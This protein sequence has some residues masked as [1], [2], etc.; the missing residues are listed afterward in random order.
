MTYYHYEFTAFTE[1]D[2]LQGGDTNLGSGDSFVMSGGPSVCI[3]TWDD[4][5]KL[6]GDY[7]DNATD[8]TG[9]YASVDGARVG[10]QMYAESYLTLR[11]SDGN[12]Y[13]LI[14]IEVEG[15][16]APGTGDDF[17]TF[18][19]AVP[20]A[21]VELTVTA[22]NDV[23]GH[24]VDY[25]CLSAGDKAPANTPPT[26]T[27]LPSDG[28]ITVDEN[29]TFVI[30]ANATDADGDTL[31]Y[32]IVGGRD[33][34]FFDIDAATGE[35]TFKSGPD[36]ENPQSGGNNNTYDVTIKVSDGNGGE[37]TKALWVKVNDVD[38]SDP[39]NCIEVLGQNLIVN[40]DFEDNALNN[41]GYG[42]FDSLPG[43]VAVQDRIE[44]QESDYQTGNTEGNAVAELDG[45]LNAIIR[46]EV[47]ITDAGTY[48][49][50][51]DYAARGTDWSTNGFEIYIDGV[52][53]E[54]VRPT[55]SG[56]QTLTF[57][58]ELD[59]GSTRIDL[60]GIGDSD[61]RGTVVDNVMLQHVTE[62]SCECIIIEAENMDLSGFRA[63]T[64]S[65]ASG[66][67]LVSM[68]HLGGTGDLSTTFTGASGSYELKLYA[69]DENDG[70]STLMVKVNGHVVKTIVLNQDGDGS[71]SDD[72]G[73]TAFTVDG[74][75][76]KSGDVV[77]IWAD[78]D[79]GEW[80][81]IDKIE[82]CK[83]GQ[84]CPEGY[85]KLDFEGLA[86]GTVV[87]DQFE[88]VTITAQRERNNT[89][90]NDAMIFDSNNWS[91]DDS[92]LSYDN[93]GNILIVSTDNN[94]SNP[95][96]AIGSSIVFDF[97]S[98]SDLH[99][100]VL[101]DIEEEGGTI[102]LTFEDGSTRV[103]DIPG[104][105]DNSIQTIDLNAA[106]VT[107][108]TIHLT[109]SGAVDDLCW[110][111]GEAVGS[112][113]GT[114][115]C[116]VECDGI[117]G[118]AGE[119]VEGCDYTIEA[120]DMN[121]YKFHTVEAADASGGEIVKLVDY[122]GTGDLRTD[123]AGKDGVY[124]VTIFA[125]DENDGQSTIMFKVNDELV[126]AVR[127]D[128]D[129]DGAGDD[130]GY[131]SQ[132]LI[133]G[134]ELSAGDEILMWVDGDDGEWVRI[135]KIE[136][137]GRDQ[138]TEGTSEPVK[139]GVTIKLIDVATDTVIATTTTDVDG[140]YEFTNVPVG[141]YKVMGVA[142]DGTEFTIQDAGT[143]DTIDSDVNDEGMSDVFTVTANSNS[144]IDLGVCD[145]PEL[146]SLS[147]RYFCDDNRDGL[148][149]DANNAVAGVVVT[150]LD[151]SG[152]PVLDGG[153]PVTTMTDADGN[154]S[155]AD[156]LPGDY[157]VRFE[158]T[159]DGKE[160]TAQDVGTD[161][162]IDSDAA[163]SGNGTSTIQGI[164]VTAGQDTPNNDVGV[165][166]Q[167]GSLSGT[168]FCDEDRD[169]VD[170]GAA[171]GD[172]DIAGK[173][174]TLYEADG[175]T[176]ATDIDGNP[177]APVQTDA[178]GDYRFDNLAAGNYVVV[179][180]GSD[181][182]AFV[183]QDT[184]SDDTIDSDVDATG[185][186]APVGVVAG[187]ETTDVDAGVAYI[188]GSLS[189]TYFCDDNR[190]G[191]DDGAANG[192]ADIAGKLVTLLNADG[193]PATDIDGNPV[194]AVLT[195]ANGDYSFDN[196]AAGDYKVMFEATDGK[197]FIAQ[198]A[199]ND[200]TD[201]SDV[202]PATGMTA[203]VTVVAGQNTPD[204][205]AG[206]QY[207]LGSLSGRY[208]CDDNRD[209]LDNDANNAVAGVV[210]T[211]LDAA[212]NPVLDGG[213]PV[214]TMTDADGN[215]SFGDLLPG[216]YG[217]R[218]ES[219]PD[220]KELTAQD[221]GTDDAID[222][223]A[224][225][226]GNG[227]STIQGI[228]VTAGQD[229]PNND[230]GVIYQPGSL[231]GTYFCDEDR[232]GVDDGAANGDLDI[233]GKTV[234][235]YEA[236]GVTPATDIDG[237][238]VAPVQT[239]ANGDYRFD[240][241]AAGNYVV[242]FEGSDDKAFVGQ[243]TGSDDTIDSDVDA[244]GTTA[245]VGV[246]AGEE[247]TDVD[248]GVAYLPGSLSGTYFC[249]DNRDGDDDGAA[250]GDADI[251]GK[252]VTL[253]NADGTPATD[254]D[255]NPVAPVLTDANGDY[256][257]D[258]LAAGDYKVMFEATDGKEFI[259]QDAG[260]DDTDDSDVDPA[261]GMTAPVTV[262]A[263]Q[264][265]PDV[266]A[267]VQDLLGSVSGTYFCDEN[268]NGAFDNE[269]G[270]G[271][272]SVT[273]EGA[274]DDGLFGTTD[275]ILLTT[276]TADDGTFA[277]ENLN[278]GDYKVS[279][280]GAGFV[281][282]LDVDENGMSPIIDLSAG[283]N[284]ELLAAS[285]C[286]EV[287]ST[288]LLGIAEIL[289]NAENIAGFG[290]PNDAGRGELF[291]DATD[292]SITGDI[293]ITSLQLDGGTVVEYTDAEGPLLRFD[294]AIDSNGD[295]IPSGESDDLLAYEDV[296]GNRLF[297]EGDVVLLEATALASGFVESG[298]MDF[299]FEVNGGTMADNFD[300]LIGMSV[301]NNPLFVDGERVT[302]VSLDEDF[303]GRPKGFV[304]D[305]DYDCFC[306][307]DDSVM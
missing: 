205:D 187:E 291:Y 114:V 32:E 292:G 271:N 89:A 183:D 112:V 300:P 28:I 59:A 94:S 293:K 301:G 214:T 229:T 160:L 15:Y 235:L 211:L 36:Y 13:Y 125:Q 126:E 186:T 85:A 27:N 70:Q 198:D 88:G 8:S 145:K 264:N 185:T 58:V 296:N 283:E 86:R 120:E 63:V 143:D 151:A 49:F 20:P 21:G 142:P 177:V 57:D 146:G 68:S 81:R 76:L 304:G 95:N 122:R 16:S 73:F 282:G 277:F 23:S 266:D 5:A 7:R 71:G 179:F 48:R 176:P 228:T 140:N 74:L 12:T 238:P 129:S 80:V 111:P 69:Q 258:N 108:M 212:G 115:F 274:G 265:T 234:T 1:A 252:L 66:G 306:F 202:D 181:D 270:I 225:D 41:T 178:N 92:D 159:P 284:L 25:R 24:W 30:D 123:F 209:G 241:L 303:I 242:V 255:G 155:F 47:Q 55:Q 2:L 104:V 247:T 107:K 45:D 197:E 200:D 50:S 39:D 163:D 278:A 190:D 101:L 54:T 147:G 285:E 289:E 14:E 279:I 11:G 139:E 294:L 103:V 254:I 102:T 170:D 191:D 217:V 184:G 67:E 281:A 154:Y 164:T 52:L 127:L 189:G 106:N 64:G 31:T 222:S 150:L 226:T 201:D 256:S 192:D 109:G 199:G 290:F 227:T 83:D 257:F 18:Y 124:D 87:Y 245:P 173:T 134:V 299:I 298:S 193:T 119:I 236:D 84:A 110:K 158:S 138:V 26:F 213:N 133:E 262:V 113:S 72:G 130:N 37:E 194:A 297:D 10:S 35:L 38:E 243:D 166:Y 65:Q 6:S 263:G 132:F 248:A 40:G 135:D 17:F 220:G 182:K 302:T 78:G 116:D 231:S 206:V 233:A 275:D 216:D 156:L 307:M 144:D 239:D 93:Q 157:G 167:P 180:E 223:D 99:D 269:K 62:T 207:I 208:F 174:V 9:Q 128:R 97:D 244:T 118:T 250:N 56:F 29:T 77:S 171:N 195:D 51:I 287:S 141:D 96:D 196:L 232:D 272:R 288:D 98:P 131:Y 165:V 260:N 4:D 267:G 161:D 210:V 273:L 61:C 259:A 148:D 3:S 34:A 60:K 246:V 286:L 53:Q 90:E 44:I 305:L 203:P 172:P 100:I 149:N 218:F 105:G 230:V 295:I 276:T 188:P 22:T 91:G 42:L 224:A 249:D 19:G 152:N 121:A 117:N 175:V 43:W 75:D 221:V 162:A 251:A 268:G 253:L 215:Y 46:Q 280:A 204:V 153:N 219:T 261:T 79:C 169:G 82:L 168:Y 33:A 136:L 237:N 240:N 137:E